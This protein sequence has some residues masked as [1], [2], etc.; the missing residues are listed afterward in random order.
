MLNNLFKENFYKK[1]KAI[2]ILITFF[3]LIK[4]ISKLSYNGLFNYFSKSTY[5]NVSYSNLNRYM[6]MNRANPF[7]LSLCCN[8]VAFN[9]KI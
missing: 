1:K 6:N 4:V 3:F 2:N 8:K 9:C 7:Q 5:Y